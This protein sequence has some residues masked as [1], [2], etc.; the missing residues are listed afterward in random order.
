MARIT[1]D[2]TSTFGKKLAAAVQALR[3][4][5]VNLMMCKQVADSMTG[6]GNGVLM[7]NLEGSPEFGVKAGDG[8]VFND[9]ITALT[10]AVFTTPATW[11]PPQ[12][13][14][15]LDRG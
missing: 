9:A 6:G 7:V 2:Q 12:A 8:A 15:D 11:T 3:L 1:Y 14:I 4:A 5:Q 13:V 10:V